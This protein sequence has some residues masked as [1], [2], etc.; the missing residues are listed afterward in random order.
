MRMFPFDR[1]IYIKECSLQRFY[2]MLSSKHNISSKN[3]DICGY[4]SRATGE[5]NFLQAHWKT[6]AESIFKKVTNVLN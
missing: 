2:F 1:R 4:S 3:L 6:E 5:S